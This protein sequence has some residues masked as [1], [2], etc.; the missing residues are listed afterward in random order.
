M[1]FLRRALTGLF[2]TSI[3]IGMIGFGV[4]RIYTTGDGAGS[5]RPSQ[6]Q[7]REYNVDVA[8]LQPKTVT[9]VISAYGQV[10]AWRMLE[11]RSAESGP[12]VEISPN[13][14]DGA[15]VAKDEFLFRIDQ[16]DYE[17]RVRDAEVAL[18]QASAA[19]AEA[20]ATLPLAVAEVRNTRQ[21]LKLKNNEL[22]RKSRLKGRGIVA[23][24]VTDNAK[25]DVNTAEQALNT[26]RKA[27]LSARMD[28]RSDE[29]AVERAEISLADAKKS[30]D[31]TSYGVPF[32]GSLTDVSATLGKRVAKNEKL[33][34]LIDPASLE[35]SFRISEEEFGRLL[36]EGR[37]GAVKKLKISAQLDLGTR[38][39]SLNGTLDRAASVTDLTSGG[40]TVFARIEAD[41]GL[42]IRP[43][44]FVSVK[45]FEPSLDNVASIPSIAATDGGQIQLLSSDNRIE[46]H[47]AKVLRRQTDAIIV[48]DVPFGREFI[49]ARQ[50]FLAAGVKVQPLRAGEALKPTH[51]VLS[52]ERRAKLI[53]VVKS[54]S[55]MPKFVQERLIKALKK[56]RIPISLVERMESGGGGKPPQG[57]TAQSPTAPS[58]AAS[59]PS[60]AAS[61]GPSQGGET[62]ALSDEKRSAMNQFV[63]KHQFLPDEI[64]QRLLKRLK[65]PQVPVAM[66]QRLERQMKGAGN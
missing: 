25:H 65:E 19:L 59:Q 2:L 50:P 57:P 23:E 54:R 27:E 56:K 31:D 44:D 1:K 66:V 32:P 24:A 43:G 20:K 11:I 38:R 63:K 21:Q 62:V 55:R 3:T 37:S 64:K 12:I 8:T 35:V 6:V 29:L 47:Q 36:T 53:S 26:K 4:W 28:I 41:A 33:G 61:A 17:R 52:E 60:K 18:A 42:Q 58:P 16:A 48:T 34:I 15:I 10:R 51:L 46:L 7:E 40:R 13:F 5:R 14:R 49:T 9:P 30:L 39:I 45:V 22:K